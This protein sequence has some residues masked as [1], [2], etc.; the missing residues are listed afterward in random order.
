[1]FGVPDQMAYNCRSYETTAA[2]QQNPHLNLMI[3]GQESD[4]DGAILSY[5]VVETAQITSTRFPKRKIYDFSGHFPRSD[6]WA[7]PTVVRRQ[8]RQD[9]G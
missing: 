2:C 8:E 3:L 7:N 9:A 5:S 4:P 6:R 1:M